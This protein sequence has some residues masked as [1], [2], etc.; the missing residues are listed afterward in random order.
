MKAGIVAEAAFAQ[1]GGMVAIQAERRRAIADDRRP[2][3]VLED[4][5]RSQDVVAELRARQLRRQDVAVAVRGDLVAVGNDL[6]DKRGFP[7]R[8]PTEGE[9]RGVPMTFRQVLD[10]GTGSAE[11]R[12]A[13][14]D[15]SGDGE[16]PKG[17][18]PPGTTLRCRTSRPP[19]STR[20]KRDRAWPQSLTTRV[21]LGTVEGMACRVSTIRW[22]RRATVS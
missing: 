1:D 13:E 20:L 10:D 15:P 11:R 16:R 19:T 22:A 18:F 21:E 4:L 5:A 8:Y 2:R 14:S 12:V 7:L 6:P 17:G 3:D 9:E